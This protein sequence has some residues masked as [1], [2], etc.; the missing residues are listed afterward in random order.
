MYAF[1]ISLI[2]FFGFLAIYHTVI[3]KNSIDFIRFILA[4]RKKDF[5]FSELLLLWKINSII[6]FNTKAHFF[7]S[8]KSLDFCIM[9]VQAEVENTKTLQKEQ[10]GTQLLSKLYNYRTQFELELIQ[11]QY[12]IETTYDI[13]PKQ[14]CL[15]LS[16]KV[17]SVYARVEEVT[18]S[19]VRFVMFD[20]SAAKAV[21]HKWKDDYVQVYFWR[22]GD[23]GYFYA[24][25][26]LSGKP[27]KD[28]YEMYIAHSD[29][30]RRT[31]KRKSIR[32][33]CRFEGVMFPLHSKLEFNENYERRGGI[34]CKIKNISEDG[35]MFHVRGKA[36]RGVHIKL[37]L[38]I[39]NKNVVMCGTIIRFIYDEASNTSKVHFNAVMVSELHRNT[40]LSFVYN[41]IEQQKPDI[42]SSLSGEG[43][44]EEMEGEVLQDSA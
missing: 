35:A 2:I 19:H 30:L 6:N 22:R 9:A 10:D 33:S 17:G 36:Q 43:E 39:N 8:I 11:E 41:I 21:K 23:A 3:G 25:K 29:E 40:I 1:L 26:I 27:R 14:V 4:G 32:A 18:K 42:A 16:Q 34:N 44:M 28:G 38:K 24:S 12:H 37:Q 5:S 15:L 13:E 20:S 7:S 31:Q